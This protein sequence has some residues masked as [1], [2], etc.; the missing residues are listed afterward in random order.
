MIYQYVRFQHS[1][2]DLPEHIEGPFTY[3]QAHHGIMEAETPD[4]EFVVD[5]AALNVDGTW[6]AG[7]HSS[8]TRGYTDAVFY[9]SESPQAEV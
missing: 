6:D 2:D 9:A 4:G 5:F 3:I 8:P 1:Q 7:P